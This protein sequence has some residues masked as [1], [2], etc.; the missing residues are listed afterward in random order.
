MKLLCDENP[1]VRVEAAKYLLELAKKGALSEEEI[2]FIGE[3]LHEMFSKPSV[4]VDSVTRDEV[5]DLLE[6][7]R[8]FLSCL[9]GFL[10]LVSVCCLRGGWFVVTVRV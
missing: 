1:C 9:V 3:K 4:I 6:E 8:G 2:K 7:F 5:E 10:S